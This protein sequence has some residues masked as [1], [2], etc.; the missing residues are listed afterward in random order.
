V[1]ETSLIGSSALYGSS[2]WDAIFGAPIADLLQ[3]L[4]AKT[5][6]LLMNA[7]GQ[8]KRWQNLAVETSP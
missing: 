5:N 7:T 8:A 6:Y 3:G 2:R 1:D 4:R